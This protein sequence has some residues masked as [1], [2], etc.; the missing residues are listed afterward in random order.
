MKISKKSLI[1]ASLILFFI[2]FN[3]FSQ[4]YWIQQPSPTQKKLT[5]CQ[6]LDS[7]YGWVIGDSG[8]ILRTTNSGA[9]W[10]VQQSGVT[11]SE[12]RDLTFI[13]R[14]TGWIISVDSTYKTFIL[15]T[16]NSGSNWS[17]VY[18]TDTTVILNTIFFTDNNTGYV[19]GFN[20]K[21]FKTTNNCNS[22]NEC[23]IDTTGC[24]YLFPKNDIKFI[25]AQTGFACGGVLDLQGIFLKTT[26]A[27]AIWY[28]SC[29]SAEPMNEIKL[30]GNNRIAL[31][32]GDYDLGSIY[33]ISSNMGE[34]WF[35]SQ[36]TCYGNAT[37][38]AFRTPAEVW[39]VLSFSGL[40]AVNLDS[41]KSGSRWQCI[42]T[43]GLTALYAI[44][45]FS[46]ANG[47]AFGENGS[48][49]KYNENVIGLQNNNN[50]VPGEIFL[51]Q[52]YPNPFNPETN[53]EYYLPMAA[54][55]ILKIFDV[56][57]KEVRIYNEG[58]K[59]KGRYSIKFN[60]EDLPSAVYYYRL[61]TG[62]RT[63]TKKMVL[64]K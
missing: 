47:Y 36:T 37:A 1:I 20:G 2:N 4:I 27:G 26:N 16:T 31:M 62:Y 15:K 19:S 38:F 18:F 24:L 34:T 40:F 23:Y 55:V 8:I 41:M 12:L 32:G 61:L 58:F 39:A 42:N 33:G 52:N 44:D 49:Y 17:K 13:S 7:L 14:N 6:Y 45:F 54:N 9:N 53:I 22:W 57:G 46:P 35:Y 28:S 25:N 60:A 51:Y 5:K 48:I 11:G 29:V 50:S 56:S 10:S 63:I 30:P 43:P 3:S 64:I 21:I 59:N